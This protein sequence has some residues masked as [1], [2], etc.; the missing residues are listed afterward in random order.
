MDQQEFQLVSDAI[1]RAVNRILEKGCDDIFRP[2]S[3]AASIEQEILTANADA[4]RKKAKAETLKFLQVGNLEKSSIGPT[5]NCLIAKDDSNFRQVSWID[6][7][8]AVKYLTLSILLFPNVEA[9]RLSTSLNIIHSHRQTASAGELFDPA[10]GY[11][12]FRARS[13]ELSNQFVGK[14]KVVTDVSNFFDRIGNHSLENHLLDVGGSKAYVTLLREILLFWVGDRRSFGIPVGSDASRIISEAI[15]IDID[16]KLHERGL[17]FLRYMDDF[18]FFADTKA[19]ALKSVEILTELLAEEGLSLNSKKTH[20]IQI[21]SDEDGDADPNLTGPDEHEAIDLDARVERFKLLRVSGRTQLSKYYE[22][23][24]ER[25]LAKLKTLTKEEVISAISSAGRDTF[26][27]QLKVLVK[28]FAN[29]NQDPSLLALAIN[30]RTTSIIYICDALI[31]ESHNFTDEQKK[32]IVEEIWNSFDWMKSPYPYQIPLLRLLAHEDYR[33][34]KMA[35]D[36]ID[37]HKTTDNTLFF[38]ELILS[39]YKNFDRQRIRDIALK[40]FPVAPNFLKRAI[41][42]AVSKHPKLGD[43]ERRPLIKNMKQHQSDW[44]I[45]NY[46]SNTNSNGAE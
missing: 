28:F 5:A 33:S 3:F 19:Q 29:V 17:T 44:F 8:D 23:P 31:K 13:G 25:A 45:S 38:R 27:D 10:F 39:S 34:A 11:K 35:C 4:F 16:R 32:R 40:I 24:G 36:L 22:K 42:H 2:P 18:R 43:D 21:Q 14:W 15:F 26:E 46:P 12:S 41:F 20:I 1:E 30:L 7:F 37:N 6:P 9:A